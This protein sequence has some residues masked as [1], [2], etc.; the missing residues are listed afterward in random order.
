MTPQDL[1]AA[2]PA[3]TGRD[4]AAGWIIDRDFLTKIIRRVWKSGRMLAVSSIDVQA[5]LLAAIELS[6]SPVR[7]AGMFTAPA[8]DWIVL[9]TVAAMMNLLHNTG[10]PAPSFD[11]AAYAT[12]RLAAAMFVTLALVMDDELE[13]EPGEAE[14]MAGELRALARFFDPATRDAARRSLARFNGERIAAM[15]AQNTPTPTA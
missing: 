8:D 10:D 14:I 1:Q 5:I 4:E 15:I 7:P 12:K 13:D 9:P 2:F 3:A 11:A 6:A